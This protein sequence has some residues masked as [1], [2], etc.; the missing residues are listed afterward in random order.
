MPWKK[1]NADTAARFDSALPD[2]P[3]AERKKMF[4]Y[5][6]C[7]VNGHFFTGMHEEH[8]VVIRLP[9]G[10]VAK[11]PEL[12]RAAGFDPMGNGKG[13]KDWFRIPAAIVASEANLRSLYARAFPLVKALPPKVAKARSSQPSAARAKRT[14]AKKR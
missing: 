14:P 9:D 1:A 12:A 3:V 11:L 2:D 10:L 6:A 8:T 7:F 4:G 13:M 5:P